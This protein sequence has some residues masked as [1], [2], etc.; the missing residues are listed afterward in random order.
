MESHKTWRKMA[1]IDIE[2]MDFLGLETIEKKVKEY[3]YV[4]LNT[5]V[6][7]NSEKKFLQ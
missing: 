1:I 4:A 3:K 7:S 5:K 6:K 2:G